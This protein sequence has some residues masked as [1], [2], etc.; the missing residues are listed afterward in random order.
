MR[1]LRQPLLHFLVIG[2]ALFA[3]Q[4][5]RYAT[6]PIDIEGLDAETRLQ[7]RD[8][9]VRRTG[10]MPTQIQ[11]VALERQELDS[12]ILYAEA[13]RRNFHRDDAVVL[14]RLLRD[15]NFLGIEGSD[16]E[17]IRTA[18]A[19]GVHESDEVIRR[20]MI[21]RMER[22]GRGTS[23]A[24]PTRDDLEQIYESETDRW[25]VPAR[26]SFQHVFFSADRD[27]DPEGRAQQALEELRSGADS[28]GFGDPFLHGRAFRDKSYRDMTYMFGSEFSDALAAQPPTVGQWSE[29]VPSA[30]GMHLVRVTD[31]V[32]ATIRSIDDVAAKLEQLWRDDH[33]RQALQAFIEQLRQRYNVVAPGDDV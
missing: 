10:R 31:I 6:A 13:L 14:Q 17:K 8:D 2:I 33:E 25:Q 5:Y 32:P 30:Y 12:R 20:R 9:F 3:L 29:P 22:L 4:K 7:L 15:A 23:S 18:I 16:D 21:Q 26:L 24:S 19:L 28:A 1:F 11:I 27:A